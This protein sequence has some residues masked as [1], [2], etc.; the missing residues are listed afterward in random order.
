[1]VLR[2]SD[3]LVRAM[4]ARRHELGLSQQELAN[5]ADLHRT[6]VVLYEKGDRVLRLDVALR[7]LHVLGMDLELHTRGR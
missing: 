1:M 7:L 2:D 3:E 4:R 6:Y 5:L